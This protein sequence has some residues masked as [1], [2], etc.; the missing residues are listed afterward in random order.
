MNF[1]PMY[2]FVLIQKADAETVT[3]G[4][5]IIPDAVAEAV[6]KGTVKAV[7]PG[8]V[9]KDGITIPVSVNVN[10]N[11]MY[12]PGAGQPVKVNGEQYLVMKEEDIIAILAD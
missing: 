3:K 1:K 9:T 7:G 11:V 4:G 8:R 12:Q 5:F 6:N 2:D 10:D